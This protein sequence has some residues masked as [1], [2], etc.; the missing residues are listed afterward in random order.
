METTKS[1]KEKLENWLKENKPILCPDAVAH[2][3][4]NT[5]ITPKPTIT[6]FFLIKGY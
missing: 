2:G 3:F 6:Y 5:G 4:E 1:D